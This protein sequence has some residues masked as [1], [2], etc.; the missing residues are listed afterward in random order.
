MC[1]G[2]LIT[3]TCDGCGEEFKKKVSNYNYNVK[4]KRK[5]YCSK[6]CSSKSTYEEKKDSLMSANSL[7]TRPS[8]DIGARYLL[9][10]CKQRGKECNLDVEYLLGLWATQNVCPYTGVK[11]MMP[12]PSYSGAAANNNKLLTASLDRKDS[13]VGYIKGNVQYVATVMNLAKGSLTHEQTVEFCKT[14]ARNWK[15]RL[16]SRNP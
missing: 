4:N 2:N 5:N 15:D 9:K 11:L 3:V 10:M 12:R 14:V 7:R 8:E 16:E 13:N 6:N 1:R